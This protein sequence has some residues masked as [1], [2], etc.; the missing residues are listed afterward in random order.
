VRLKET[1]VSMHISELHHF[2]FREQK[3]FAK[4][5]EALRKAGF[6]E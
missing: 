2:P 1:K 6:Q 3:Y 4:Y 5:V